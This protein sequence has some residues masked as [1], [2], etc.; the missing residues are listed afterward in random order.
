ML[1]DLWETE[2]LKDAI[3]A[4]EQQ[5]ADGTWSVSYAGG[6]FVQ[7]VSPNDARGIAVDMYASLSKR[8]GYEHLQDKSLKGRVIYVRMKD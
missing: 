7:N 2:E 6:G 8:K 3:R 4:I 1:Y 5:L